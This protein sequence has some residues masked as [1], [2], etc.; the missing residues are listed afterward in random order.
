[1]NIMDRLYSVITTVQE[2]TACVETLLQ[3]LQACDGKL[4]V[5]GDKKGPSTY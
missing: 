4:I 5:I 1:M 2:P 3:R